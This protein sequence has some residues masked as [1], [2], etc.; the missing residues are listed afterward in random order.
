LPLDPT[1]AKTKPAAENADPSEITRSYRILIIDDNRLGARALQMF[2]SKDGHQVEMAFTGPAGVEAARRFRPE[3]VL[4]D[5]ALPGL[6]GFG[7][8]QCLRQELEKLYLIAVSGY[9]RDEDQERAQQAGFDAYLTKPL[10]FRDLEKLLAEFIRK[11]D[12]P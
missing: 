11:T 4:C 12:N 9:G 2:L 6:D 8:A 5:I 7:V 10:D 1:L 3:V